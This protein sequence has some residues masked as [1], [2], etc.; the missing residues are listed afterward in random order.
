MNCFSAFRFEVGW[1]EG[2]RSNL[3]KGTQTE[4]LRPGHQQLPCAINII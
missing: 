2:M 1:D 3:V 4:K